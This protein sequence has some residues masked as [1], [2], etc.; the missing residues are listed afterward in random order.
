MNIYVTDILM[1]IGVKMNYK[2]KQVNDYE[3]L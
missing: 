2:Q 3:I 1:D